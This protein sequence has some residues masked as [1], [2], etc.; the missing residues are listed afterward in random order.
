MKGLPQDGAIAAAYTDCKST[1]LVTTSPQNPE[2]CSETGGP[3]APPPAQEPLFNDTDPIREQTARFLLANA[4]LVRRRIRGKIKWALSRDD[5]HLRAWL[6][7]DDIL[8]T[9]YRRVDAAT[10]AGN[11]RASTPAEFWGFINTVTDNAMRDRINKGNR[12]HRANGALAARQRPST[13]T[14]ADGN[15]ARTQVAERFLASRK[16]C[17][18]DRAIVNLKSR[19]APLAAIAAALKSAPPVIRIRWSTLQRWF[20]RRAGRV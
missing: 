11:L 7:V 2:D 9:V 1:P 18:G 20:R 19:S 16:L 12:Q 8:S 14:P 17:D 3:D 10:L 15:A 5:D 13:N 4:D 6:D